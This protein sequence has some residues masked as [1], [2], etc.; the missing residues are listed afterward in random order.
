M[1]SELM[2]LPKLEKRTYKV[3]HWGILLPQGKKIIEGKRMEELKEGK[4]S[5]VEKFWNNN[6]INEVEICPAQHVG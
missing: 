3:A 2:I 6:Y 4:K 1:F 5:E